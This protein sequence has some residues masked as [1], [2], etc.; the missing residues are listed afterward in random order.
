MPMEPNIYS[1]DWFEF[2]H[3]DIDEARTI[4][5]TIF[6]A[7]CAPLP[8]F[9]KILDV[10]CGMGR[11]AR[12]L[13]E[14][15]YSV[16]SVDRD[17]NMISKARELGGG[18]EYVVADIRDYAPDRGVFDAAIVMSQSFG[19]FDPATNRDVLSRL[20]TAVRGGGRIILDLWNPEFFAAHQC[21]HELK[22]A[23]GT[24]RENKSMKNDRLLV[25]L[26]YP[27][28]NREQFEWQLFSPRQMTDLARSVGLALLVSCTDF[29]ANVLPSSSN[30]RLQ[31]V[32]ERKE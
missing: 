20:A 26:E 9:R 6:I 15:G 11:H 22:T 23:R 18:P 2:F 24:V 5:E 28:R 3:V 10:C 12:A 21:E 4:Q 13:S 32:L 1:P 25:D 31:F 14:L 19:Y 8:E 7:E 30:P 17:A 16:T 27:G 29:A